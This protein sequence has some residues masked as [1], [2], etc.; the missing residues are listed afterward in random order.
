M[1]LLIREAMVFLLRIVLVDVPKGLSL[2]MNLMNK[3][4]WLRVSNLQLTNRHN[5]L[6]FTVADLGL[7]Y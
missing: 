3:V 4:K 1:P 7:V 5:Y 2:L 6:G